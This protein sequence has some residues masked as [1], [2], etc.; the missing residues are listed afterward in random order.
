MEWDSVPGGVV[1]DAPDTEKGLPV[2]GDSVWDGPGTEMGL[3]VP[4]DAVKAERRAGVI[5]RK[6]NGKLMEVV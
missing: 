3:L 5:L 2:P 1:L 4:G 6:G